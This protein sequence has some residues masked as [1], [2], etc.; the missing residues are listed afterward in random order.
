MEFVSSISCSSFWS[1]LWIKSDERDQA[2]VCDS[3]TFRAPAIE[4]FYGGHFVY[5]LAF[6][7]LPRSKASKL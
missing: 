7:N 6:S 3:Y 5:L 1:H 4:E 2:F